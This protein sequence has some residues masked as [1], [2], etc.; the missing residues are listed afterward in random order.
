MLAP[1]LLGGEPVLECWI[2]DALSNPYLVL[3]AILTAGM[4]GVSKAAKLPVVTRNELTTKPADGSCPESLPQY[5]GAAVEALK[6]DTLLRTA[7]G[8]LVFKLY[9]RK[10]AGEWNEFLR[11]IHPWEIERYLP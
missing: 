1:A 8:D 4:E 3:A 10:K 7:L 9:L 11:E 2:P 5:L 6:G